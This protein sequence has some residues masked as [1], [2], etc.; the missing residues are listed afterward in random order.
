MIRKF[1]GDRYSFEVEAEPF[2]DQFYFSITTIH[3][4]SRRSSCINTLNQILS[5]FEIGERDPRQEQSDWLLTKGE[6][7]RFR[8]RARSL[9]TRRSSIVFMESALDEDRSCGEWENRKTS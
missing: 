7:L 8:N 1:K 3:K 2:H 9:F 4:K 6:L 5:E